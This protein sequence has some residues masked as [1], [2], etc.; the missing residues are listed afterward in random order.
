MRAVKLFS[1]WIVLLL[2]VACGGGGGKS[3]SETTSSGGGTVTST[4]PV[5][6]GVEAR[7]SL[8]NAI[9][10]ISSLDVFTLRA[11]LKDASGAPKARQLV[12][13]SG[14][15]TLFK[16]SPANGSALTDSNGLAIV[17]VSPA[18]SS[19][20]GSANITVEATGTLATPV[21]FGLTVRPLVGGGAS[22]VT[23]QMVDSL[24]VATSAVTGLNTNTLRATVKDYL[25]NPLPSQV[26]TFSSAGG[27]V[28]INPSSAV[29]GIDGV[30]SVSVSRT[31]ASS[32]GA[33]SLF[34][35]VTVGGVAL[36][37]ARVNVTVAALA[38]GGSPTMT[39]DLRNSVNA[40]ITTVSRDVASIT[41]ARVELRDVLGQ[42]VSGT[43][44]ALSGGAG[45]V[46]YAPTT[47]LTDSL[48]VA[49][50]P[51]AAIPTSVGGAGTLRATA[52]VGGVAL[53]SSFDF[54]VPAATG[55][56]GV[57]TLSLGL[58]GGG[59]SVPATGGVAQATVTD[60]SGAR[61]AGKIVTFSGNAS[62]VKF[63]PASGQVL[64][65]S[66]G[67]ASI[68]IA[69][70]S[71]SSYGASTLVAQ[72]NVGT[73]A[74][75]T[76][77]DYQL[78]AA[79]IAFGALNLGSGSLAAYGTR[80][81]SVPVT[82]DGTAATSTPVTVSF[83]AT[84]GTV[85]PSVVQTDSTG[86]ATS[87]YTANGSAGCSATSVGITASS[88][89]ASNKLGSL[90]VS[91]SLA[92][93][94]QF[95]SASPQTIY[96]SGSVGSTQ[97]QLVFK[98]L[99]AN[100]NGLANKTVRIALNNAGTGVSLNVLGSTAAVDLTSD[101]TGAVT[102]AVF[103]GTVPTSFT[104]KATYLDSNGNVT[105]ITSNSNVLTVASGRPVKSKLSIALGLRV[106]EGLS[107]DG[108]TTSVTLSMADRQGNPVP[109]GTQVNFVT[110]SGL[111]IPSTCFTDASSQCS[112]QYRS[113]GTRPPNGR[114]T[115]M[116]YVVGEEEFVDA[117]GDN[118]Y[119]C[120]ESFTDLPLAYRRDNVASSSNTYSGPGGNYGTPLDTQAW[121]A[122]E[123]QVPRT[124]ETGICGGAGSQTPSVTQGDG[125]WGSA[126]I[127]A[128]TSIGLAN[129]YANFVTNTRTRTQLNVT[130]SD[131][132]YYFNS[133]PSG[134]TITATTT[135][136]DSTA[137]LAT[138]TI[139]GG[140]KTTVA[141]TLFPTTFSVGYLCDAGDIITITVVTPNGT[142]T[143]ADFTVP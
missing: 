21:L 38:N 33:E 87:S 77:F 11:T 61:V 8:N 108:K 139:L 100:G 45:L 91:P 7:D 72:A 128:Q 54:L 94:I 32:A 46:S 112:V 140:A 56:G 105:S 17:Q 14:D 132:V 66:T 53:A 70:V 115:I 134:S 84:C 81:I 75:S 50:F 138:C 16:F 44:V 107:T 89:G 104:V 113:Q 122:G 118:I 90:V 12:K 42:V 28:K 41:N 124:G 63:S 43:A 83:A 141:N 60:A 1:C 24:G 96:L 68:Q 103:S 79:N 110:Q 49:L 92:T 15:T 119:N 58:L 59:N 23:L 5:I 129:G 29:T 52:T 26:V 116:A 51:I 39:L 142:T 57:A 3:G 62:L 98:V 13:F 22:T 35:N 86:T 102:V 130:I 67:V 136:A 106:I 82:I 117:N 80:T 137:G 101:S 25:G 40:A 76:S 123:F 6:S 126:D 120:G 20:D 111:M 27:L 133:V 74:L 143:A 9:T 97:S 125:V 55:G 135:V 93:N 2:L 73:S 31:A 114:S 47:A 109:P 127:D 69:P 95:V 18:S 131:S 4:A 48:G 30:A 34:A 85:T 36:T 78:A 37:P 71:L 121:Y 64:T 99:D 19:S 88:S 65:D 10:D